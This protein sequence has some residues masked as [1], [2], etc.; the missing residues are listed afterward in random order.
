MDKALIS[1]EVVNPFSGATVILPKDQY[2]LYNMI[3]TISRS[4]RD[5]FDWSRPDQKNDIKLMH[6]GL[7]WFR[8]NNL[9]AYMKLLD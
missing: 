3:I 7:N 9:P 4:L 8:T 1:V 6:K 5:G 2:F